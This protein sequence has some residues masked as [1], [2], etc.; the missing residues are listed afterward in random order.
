M[1]DYYLIIVFSPLLAAALAG[2]GGRW[3]GRTGAHTV[4]ILGVGAACV[5][6]FV[7]LYRMYWGG[8]P[9]ENISLYTWA[10]SDGL[11]MEIGFL[12]DR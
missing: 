6:S 2:L 9:A 10:V 12:V 11:R 8:A 1:L 4:T 7:V 3:I 5:L